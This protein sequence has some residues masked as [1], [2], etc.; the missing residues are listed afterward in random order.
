[1]AIST[2]TNTR[3]FTDAVSISDK[4]RAVM[5]AS[6][7]FKERAYAMGLPNYG[8]IFVEGFA[9]VNGLVISDID[10][11][12][13][14]VIELTDWYTAGRKTNVQTILRNVPAE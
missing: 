7:A 11:A 10:K 8:E 1:M 13:S 14:L 6:D 12:I 2:E 3:F 9:D 4:I 5:A